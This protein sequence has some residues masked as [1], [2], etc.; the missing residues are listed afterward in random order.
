MTVSELAR[1][2][3]TSA[4]TVR[5]YSRIGLLPYSKDPVNGYKRY[6]ADAERQLRFILAAR[7]LGFSL[8]DIQQIIH[9]ARQGDSACPLVRQLISRRLAETEQHFQRLKLLRK[10][11]QQAVRQWQQLPDKSPDGQMLC[12]LIENF[13]A[14]N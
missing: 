6:G 5:Y 4:D 9:H 11:M 2:L 12:H 1:K 8:E 3:A 13:D 7:Q 14:A 10:R